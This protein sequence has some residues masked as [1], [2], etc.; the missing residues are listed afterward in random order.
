MFKFNLKK[1]TTSAIVMAM[2]ISI[3]MLT[4]SFAFLQ[5]QVRIST[6]LYILPALMPFLILPLAL[7]N[8][9]SNLFLGSLGILDAIGGFLSALLTC[10][11]VWLLSKTKGGNRL[12]ALPIWLIPSIIVPAFISHII[13]VPYFVLV[14]SLLVGQGIS[15]IAGHLFYLSL[16]RLKI[17]KTI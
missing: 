1:I 15:A 14:V 10:Y 17:W 7:A 16:R 9:I 12:I 3:M 11:S 2:Y 6:A 4:Q 5:Y 8:M 13:H